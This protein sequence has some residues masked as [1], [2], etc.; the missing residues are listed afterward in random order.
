ME[1]IVKSIGRYNWSFQVLLVGGRGCEGAGRL[2][3]SIGQYSDSSWWGQFSSIFFFTY[4][5]IQH[6]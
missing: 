5:H 4:T 3:Y 1:L 2:E 6:S